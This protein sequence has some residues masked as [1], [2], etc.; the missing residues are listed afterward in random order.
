[1]P[2]LLDLRLSPPATGR[3]APRFDA[4]PRSRARGPQPALA[5]D[6]PAMAGLF[7]DVYGHDSSHPAVDP[8]FIRTSLAAGDAWVVVR[9]AGRI[10][11]CAAVRAT[12]WAGVAELGCLVIDPRHRGS[13]LAMPLME[14]ALQAAA[15]AGDVGLLFAR[16][17]SEAM[18][19]KTQQLETMQLHLTGHDGGIDLAGGRP[20]AHGTSVGL[21]TGTQ[22]RAALPAGHPLTELEGMLPWLARA[23]QGTVAWPDDVTVGPSGTRP[24]SADD[25]APRPD[26]DPLT[27]AAVIP[28]VQASSTG[29]ALR[30][31]AAV[32]GQLDE[33]RVVTAYVL[34]DKV[35]LIA[36]SAALGLRPT[37]WL[38]AWYEHDG[39]RLDCVMLT[40]AAAVADE[41]LPGPAGEWERRL[42]QA[43]QPATVPASQ[44]C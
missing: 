17:R 30:W 19:R 20:E 34:A 29:S 7:A 35:E 4:P 31:L 23:G 16:H 37:A 2:A 10:V 14:R 38:P 39:H 13:R 44:A 3:F 24:R 21:G 15:A 42:A 18:V 40:R 5:S 32:L 36:A 11:G 43:L 26:I 9:R 41:A 6:A 8:A 1:M 25:P 22:I 28:P 12:G 27:G 33:A